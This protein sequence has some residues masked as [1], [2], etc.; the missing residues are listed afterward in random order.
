MLAPLHLSFLESGK[1]PEIFPTAVPLMQ[2]G[3]MHSCI[4]DSVAKME[5]E[6]LLPEDRPAA[7]K[8]WEQYFYQVLR[9][10]GAKGK[11]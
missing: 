5:C 10:S 7:E 2:L 11:L 1:Y 8:R 3:A 4:V 6:A 9:I